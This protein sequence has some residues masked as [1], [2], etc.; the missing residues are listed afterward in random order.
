MI[1]KMFFRSREYSGQQTAQGF[2]QRFMADQ[3]QI[4]ANA[5][6]ESMEITKGYDMDGHA[7]LASVLQV[8]KIQ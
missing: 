1:C 4:S 5:D 6:Q 8:Y 3:F 2:S 7:Q